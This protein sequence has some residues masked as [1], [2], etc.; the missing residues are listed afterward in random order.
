MRKPLNFLFFFLQHRRQGR[1]PSPTLVLLAEYMQAAP[2]ALVCRLIDYGRF[3]ASWLR[4]L[5]HARE[6]ETLVLQHLRTRLVALLT[7][8]ASVWLMRPLHSAATTLQTLL[9]EVWEEWA[10]KKKKEVS[11]WARGASDLHVA[12]Y[13]PTAERHDI[14]LRYLGPWQWGHH[15]VLAYSPPLKRY[16][17]WCTV[18]GRKRAPTLEE[19]HGCLLT[20]W[21]VLQCFEAG[22]IPAHVIWGSDYNM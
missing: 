18:G 19:V 10:D 7:R 1:R 6:V 3:E 8:H 22:A 11:P 4:W 12:R 21:Q 2:L 14:A 16:F 20:G 9:V 5:P 15:V 13:P 17:F